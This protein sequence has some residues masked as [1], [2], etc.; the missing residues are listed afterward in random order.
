MNYYVVRKGKR[1]GIYR[2]WDECKAQVHGFK[3]AE[4]KKFTNE[5][6]ALAFLNVGHQDDN[7]QEELIKPEQGC[8]TAYVDGS[9]NKKTSVYGYGL[10]LFSHEG[11]KTYSGKFKDEDSHSR[12]V[13]GEIMAARKAMSMALEEGAKKLN[14]IYDYAGLRHWALGEWKTN[15]ELTKQYK[16]FAQAVSKKV[17]LNFIKVKSHTGNKYNEEADVLA[18]KACGIKV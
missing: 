14:I 9:F 16:E 15:L 12:N 5:K 13:S 10:V 3:G 6:D 7:D 2:T 1:P 4:F 17:K 11:K 8:L 18:K